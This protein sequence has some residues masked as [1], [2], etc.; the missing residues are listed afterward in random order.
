MKNLFKIAFLAFALCLTYTSCDTD[1]E[2]GVAE[3]GAP[4]NPEKETAGVYTG[5]WTREYNGD[6]TTAEGT[7]T[8]EAGETAYITNVTAVCTQFSL[9]NTSIANITPSGNFFQNIKTG[10]A[11]GFGVTFSGKAQDGTATMAFT[12]TQKAGRKTLTYN[13]SFEGTRTE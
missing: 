11:N 7:V 9:N 1:D 12:L 8:L 13:Y 5:T 2:D 10:T 6:I 4:T 3:T